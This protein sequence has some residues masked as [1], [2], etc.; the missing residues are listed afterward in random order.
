MVKKKVKLSLFTCSGGPQGCETLR[1]PN[2]L[3]NSLADGSEVVSL[4]H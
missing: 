3:D 2:F 4:M 1:L